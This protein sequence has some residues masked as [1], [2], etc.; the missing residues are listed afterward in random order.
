MLSVGL[1]I[2]GL[3]IWGVWGLGLS[4]LAE[5]WDGTGLVND[6]FGNG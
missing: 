1:F 4:S 3:L 6:W 5:V 2:R